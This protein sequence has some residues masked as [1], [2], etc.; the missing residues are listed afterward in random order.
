MKKQITFFFA[1]IFTALLS[2]NNI[3]VTNISLTGQNTTSGTT[4]VQ[5]DIS[6]E[7]SWRISVAPNNWDAAWVFVKYRTGSGNWNHATLNTTGHTAPTGSTVAPSSDGMGAF[8]YRSY[9]GSG[10]FSLTDVELSWNYS[11][12][13]VGNSDVVDVQVFAIEMV[14]V[15]LGAFSLGSGGTESGAFYKYPTTT[16]PYPVENENE[17][18]VG[19]TAGNLYYPNTSTYSGDQTGTIAAGFP[20]GYNAF[21]CMKYEISQ[22]D[23]VDFLNSLTT[24]QATNRYPGKTTERHGITVSGNIYS[25]T[26]PYVACNW[27]SWAD[28][29]AYMDWSGLRPMTELEFEKACRGT[30]A[31]VPN[32]YA[33]GSTNITP[34]TGISNAGASNETAT[35]SGA[36]V[37]YN[38][39]TIGPLRAGSFATSSSTRETSGATYYG[40]MEMSGNLYERVV[41]VGNATGRGF[42]GT[43]GN[44]VLTSE[45]KADQSGWPGTNA[46]GAGF[47]GGD[48]FNGAEFA[49]IADRFIAASTSDVRD[50]YFGGRGIRLAP[51]FVCGEIITDV[52]D[53]QVYNTVQ[54]GTQCWMAQNMNI[55]TKIP[56]SSSQINNGIIEKYC[57]FDDDANCDNYGGLYQ[58]PEMM[59]Y[60][61]TE[62]SQ[63]ICPIGWHLPNDAAWSTLITFLGGESIAGGKMKTTG[64]TD[65]L[66]PN[67]GA[68]NESGFSGFPGG[69]Y[70]D[71]S[72]DMWHYI[73]HSGYWWSTTQ[74]SSVGAYGLRIYYNWSDANLANLLRSYGFSVR[75]LK[76]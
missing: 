30:A 63:G 73:G 24:T 58:W 49:R 8:I 66:S 46:L 60:V 25:T 36:N 15:P 42:N 64:T 75:C 56:G 50:Y 20:K 22:Q 4:L 44:G 68:T 72:E 53:N 70:L 69:L 51:P 13:G 62:G 27:L 14:Y 55:G 21:Y 32:E 19:S 74:S 71:F 33:W 40:I 12:N 1:L 59:E 3:S 41:T 7:N 45:G 9:D 35:N 38:S 31:A 29:A 28:V 43:Q 39:L 6:W 23:Y 16:D 61:T 34:A 48:W 54:I 2:A 37:C 18:N 17:I 47:R 76:N 10:T 57:Y 67:T 65:W 26:L 5:F 11:T 52:R